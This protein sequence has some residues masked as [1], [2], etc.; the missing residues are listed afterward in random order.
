VGRY[1][2][3]PTSK[4]GGRHERCPDPLDRRSSRRRA[5]R[6]GKLEPGL[7]IGD[8]LRRSMTQPF[9]LRRLTENAWWVQSSN[10]GTV[11]YVGDDGILILDALEGVYDRQTDPPRGL[12]R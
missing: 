12:K 5:F 9:V 1:S 8:L 7:E 4:C 3:R 6:D 2:V 11:L 10:Y